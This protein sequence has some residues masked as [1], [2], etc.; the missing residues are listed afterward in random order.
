MNSG[1]EILVIGGRG[2]VGRALLS[3]DL[4]RNCD[5]VAPLRRELDLMVRSDV[6][7]AVGSRRWTCVVNAAAYTAVDNAE[8]EENEHEAWQ[9]NAIGPGILSEITGRFNIPL[10][11]LSTDYVFGGDKNGFYSENDDVSPLSVYGKSKRAGEEAVQRANPAHLIVR[12]SW[13]F[14]AF[15]KNFVNTMLGLAQDNP[16]ISVVN[17]QWGRPTCAKDLAEAISQMVTSISVNGG[18]W[19]VYHFANSGSASWFTFANKI[20]EISRKLGGPTATVTPI[21]GSEFKARAMRPANSQLSTRKISR[22][23]GISP[24]SYEVA[25]FEVLEQLVG[26]PSAPL[27]ER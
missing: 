22:D 4:F 10:I 26:R 15:G 24:R 27:E 6:E 21:A 7:A 3:D 20:F 11:H 12:T 19:G 9:V 13:I 16:T 17:D 25:L 18:P 2:Q 5:V 1:A 8:D 14:G 23:F